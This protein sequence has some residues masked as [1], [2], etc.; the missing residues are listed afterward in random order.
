M[1]LNPTPIGD[2]IAEYLFNNPPPAGT[3]VGLPFLKSTWE[4][5][6][7][8]IYNDIKANA[9]II[10]DTFVSSPVIP[11]QVNPATGTGATTAS[12]PILG[13]GKVT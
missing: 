1:P 8:L 4:Q 3:P 12:E 13:T 5:V 2:Q 10:P 9:I 7:T 6:M 11:V